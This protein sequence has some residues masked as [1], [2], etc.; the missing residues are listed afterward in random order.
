MV[1]TETGINETR[2]VDEGCQTHASRADFFVDSEGGAHRGHD[3]LSCSTLNLADVARASGFDPAR[4]C[5]Y[6]NDTSRTAESRRWRK[7][8]AEAW[9]E[10][11]RAE[12]TRRE[13]RFLHTVHAYQRC[14][15]FGRFRVYGE[16]RKGRPRIVAVT[17]FCWW[18][19]DGAFWQRLRA[20]AR[21]FRAH[22]WVMDERE[23]LDHY[24]TLD[25]KSEEHFG[26]DHGRPE[27]QVEL[28]WRIER[29]TVPELRA[30]LRRLKRGT[31]GLWGQCGVGVC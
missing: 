5:D 22:V 30:L 9:E 12:L 18:C 13:H 8:L 31:Q 19:D 16:L 20:I 28:S 14:A 7:A 23:H 2:L 26:P 15:D 27:R 21:R 10:G 1:Q 4:I 25:E 29:L 3:Y 17:E 6:D 11:Y 24:W